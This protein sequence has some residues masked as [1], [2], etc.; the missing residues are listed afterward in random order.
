MG[1]DFTYEDLNDQDPD[2]YDFKRLEDLENYYL[3]RAS[4]PDS[5]QYSYVDFEIVKEKYA[6][7]K[8]HYYDENGNQI[9]RLEAEKLEQITDQL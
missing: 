4:N 5:D 8:I 6:L 2:D 9:K 1:S 7:Q 3:V